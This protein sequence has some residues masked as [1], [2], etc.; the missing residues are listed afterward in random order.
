MSAEQCPNC[1]KYT[2]KKGLSNKAAG[3]LS[4]FIGIALPYMLVGGAAAYG[5]IILGLGIW[6]IIGLFLAAYGLIMFFIKERTVTYSCNEC[7]YSQQYL[8]EVVDE[9]KE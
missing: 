2:F 6:H 3:C 4:M 9:K 7:K 8:L 5:G 1:G